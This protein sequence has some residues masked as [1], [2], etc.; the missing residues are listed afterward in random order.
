MKIKYE[1]HKV[2]HECFQV[3]LNPIVWGV[4]RQRLIATFDKA[5]KAIAFCEEKNET[6]QIYTA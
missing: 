2:T 4:D 5:S 3:W 1:I 6:Y